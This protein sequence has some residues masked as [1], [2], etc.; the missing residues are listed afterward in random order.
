MLEVTEAAAA[1][2]VAREKVATASMLEAMIFSISSAASSAT[3]AA[4]EAGT[5]RPS[6]GAISAAPTAATANRLARSDRS[7]DNRP[8]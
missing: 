3:V 7:W 5:K 2:T 8:R 1:T 4:T 6:S